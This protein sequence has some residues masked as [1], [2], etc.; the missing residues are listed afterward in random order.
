MRPARPAAQSRNVRV[1][2]DRV[3]T[4]KPR[5][6]QPLTA[7]EL[8]DLGRML[9]EMGVGTDQDLSHAKQNGLGLFIRSLVGLDRE[10]AKEAFSQ[11]IAG[12]MATANQIEF[13]DLV[14]DYLTEHGLMEAALLYESPL[15]DVSPQGPEAIFSSAQVDRMISILADIRGKAAA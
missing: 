15:T 12:G 8:D 4:Q 5:R 2:E 6:N 7:T 3:A 9:I 1:R 13:I 11:F 14:V 10:A